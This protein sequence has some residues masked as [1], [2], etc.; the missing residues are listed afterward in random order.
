MFLSCHVKHINPSNK[1]ADR[2]LKTDKKIAEE[3]DYD[4]IE[5][6][7]QEKDFN[8]IEVEN[9]ICINVFG[10]EYRLVFPIYIS[11]QKFKDSMDLLLLNDNNKSHYVYI[12]DFDRFMLH[13]KK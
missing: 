7:V 4:E 8:K 5:F 10:Y 11:D 12:K 2:I 6:P 3:P 9:N 13:K 1:H